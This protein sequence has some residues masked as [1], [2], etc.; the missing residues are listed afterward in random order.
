MGSSL[1]VN[2]FAIYPSAS[3]PYALIRL[4]IQTRC[5]AA[6]G[7]FGARCRVT[8]LSC[9]TADQLWGCSRSAVFGVLAGW[10]IV[11]VR[12]AVPSASGRRAA[13]RSS[14]NPRVCRSPARRCSNGRPSLHGESTRLL[15]CLPQ[16]RLIM[17]RPGVSA[18]TSTF[19]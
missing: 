15:S 12:G 10:S 18:S 16:E 8:A 11:T 4:K 1:L 6:A 19:H 9:V 13:G 17:R 5:E 3:Q 14:A 7:N 2:C